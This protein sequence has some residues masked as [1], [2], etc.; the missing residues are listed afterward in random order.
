MPWILKRTYSTFSPTTKRAAKWLVA[1][2]TWPSA[3]RCRSAESYIFRFSF[4]KWRKQEEMLR[5]KSIRATNNAGEN[6][7][8][9]KGL[10]ASR[11]PRRQIALTERRRTRSICA[12]AIHVGPIKRLPLFP[13]LTKPPLELHPITRPGQNMCICSLFSFSGGDLSSIFEQWWQMKPYP[14]QPCLT[15]AWKPI[16]VCFIG[17]IKIAEDRKWIRMAGSPSHRARSL[18]LGLSPTPHSAISPRTY[19]Q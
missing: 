19:C 16:Y 9:G 3:R 12:F 1:F 18:K 2:L 11:W 17:K 4:L 13:L 8:L 10:L 14:L 7:F 6:R 5:A 15:H